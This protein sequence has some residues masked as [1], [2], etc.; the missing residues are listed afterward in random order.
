MTQERLERN[1]VPSSDAAYA[2][3]R[4]LGNITLA[5]ED[6]RAVWMWRWVDSVAQ[7]LR[8]AAR[9]L[10]R[11]PGF[12]IVAVTTLALGIGAS[13]ALFSAADAVL[14]KP[15]PVKSPEQLVL[16]T[17][18]SGPQGLMAGSAAGIYVD[19]ASGRSSS[20]AFS[21]LTFRAFQQETRT[22]SEVFAFA[23]R[24]VR[25][26]DG[27]HPTGQAVGQLVSGNY[28]R[29]LGVQASLGRVIVAEDDR[30]TAEPVVV[31]SHRYWRRRF[32]GDPAAIGKTIPFD[33]AVATIVGVTPD[34]FTVHRSSETH[35]IFRFHSPWLRAS[36]E[37][38]EVHGAT[39]KALVWP[40][41]L[42]GRLKPGVT[43]ADVR[44]D[45]QGAFTRRR[46]RAG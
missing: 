18:T 31:S 16:F 30:D 40:L 21:K 37:A 5:R 2:S 7:D 22:L 33:T 23:D 19:P 13:T 11:N 42:M 35:P 6:A 45:L 46:S 8:Y 10:R 14:L 17:W 4:T 20:R 24:S 41:R 3:R 32:G 27:E 25:T 26:L 36:A 44:G 1:G 28:F 38:I 15:L 9:M 12:A 43:L 29:A 39:G 34:G